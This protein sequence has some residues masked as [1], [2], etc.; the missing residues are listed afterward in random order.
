LDGL[1]ALHRSIS[2]YT[3]GLDYF[4]KGQSLRVGVEYRFGDSP[5]SVLAGL[6]FL[7]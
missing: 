4:F 6:K 2:D 7:L 3:V 5:D 1:P